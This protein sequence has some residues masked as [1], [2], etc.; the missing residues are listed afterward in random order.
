[1]A[2]HWLHS[3]RSNDAVSFASKG[4][5]SLYLASKGAFSNASEGVS[6]DI[7]E[8]DTSCSSVSQTLLHDTHCFTISLADVDLE[9]LNT[10]GYFDTN[11]IFFVCDNSSTGH[12]CNCLNKF[13]LGSLWQTNK[14]LTTANGTG[15]CLHLQLIDDHGI[16]HIFILDKC[17]YHPNSPVNLL[18]T[19]RLAEKFID[20][21]GNLDEDTMIELC[22][23]TQILT[24]SFGQFHKTFLTPVPALY[25]MKASMPISPLQIQSRKK[26][27]WFGIL[28]LHQK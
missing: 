18:S 2:C 4:D 21:N 27:M 17:L 15:A 16:Q 1:M 13:V 19:W 14:S 7:S 12:I 25:L 22:Y 3:T 9:Q 26:S 24:W 20:A 23:S 10:Q 11:S 28:M 8:G 5:E 6:L